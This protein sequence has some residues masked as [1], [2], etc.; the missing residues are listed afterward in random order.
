MKEIYSVAFSKLEIFKENVILG[1]IF[2]RLCFI[3]YK[4]VNCR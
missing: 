4:T 1:P 2:H 3:G